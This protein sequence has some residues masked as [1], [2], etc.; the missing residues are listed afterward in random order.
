MKR[1]P[2]H[3]PAVIHNRLA[4]ATYNVHQWIGNDGKFDPDRSLCVLEEL[5]CGIIGLQEANLTSNGDDKFNINYFADHLGMKAVSLPTLFRKTGHFGNL[6]LT[7]YPV[8]AVRK[9]NLSVYSKEPRAAIDADLNIKG[10]IV[11]VIVTHLGLGPL[12]R[13]FQLNKLMEVIA[14]KP[15]YM[16]IVL[17][18]FNLWTPLGRALKR[19][20]TR[21][22]ASPAPRTYPANC[23]IFSL[24]RIWVS[25]ME[26]LET[27]AAHQ[28]S[29]SSKASDH[30]PLRAVLRIDQ[31]GGVPLD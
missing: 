4:V 31:L 28:T 21:F 13:R 6:L 2:G 23:P 27:L 1:V 9:V 12:E 7:S 5:N 3:D 29:I 19:I 10:V 26:R 22:A 11:R 15:S 16:T 25:P 18:D 30:L 8:E 14:S 24:D 17:G 20:R